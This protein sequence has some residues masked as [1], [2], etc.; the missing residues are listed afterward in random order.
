[1]LL[2]LLLCQLSKNLL[3]EVIPN[4]VKSP[5]SINDT[6]TRIW[7]HVI[8]DLPAFVRGVVFQESQKASETPGLS[9][10]AHQRGGPGEAPGPKTRGLPAQ[11]R[12]K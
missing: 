10:Q 8:M 5:K 11:P 2:L 9:Q 7:S 3:G 4:Q 1:M 12:L 6:T